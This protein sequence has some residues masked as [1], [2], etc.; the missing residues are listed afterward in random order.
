[1]NGVPLPVWVLQQY[2]IELQKQKSKA[3]KDHDT[4]K[5]VEASENIAKISKA[6]VAV[7]KYG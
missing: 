5:Y 7:L 2:E 6:I 4:N 3:L 1:M